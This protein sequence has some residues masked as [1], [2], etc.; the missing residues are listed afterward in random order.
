MRSITNHLAAGVDVR[1]GTTVT[2]IDRVPEGWSLRIETRDRAAVASEPFESVVM[3]GMP[4][5]TARV[6]GQHSAKILQEIGN[7]TAVPCWAHT[8]LLM[9][10]IPELPSVLR[11]SDDNLIELIVRDDAKPGRHLHDDLS[12]VVAYARAAWSASEYHAPSTTVGRKIADRLLEL[13]RSVTGRDVELSEFSPAAAHRWGLARPSSINTC[14][15]AV[16]EAL[17]LAACGD[18]FAGSG[19]EAAFLSGR[20]A[21]DAVLSFDHQS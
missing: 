14:E 1:A 2:S 19:L 10:R 3:A 5:Q 11:V 17:R 15:Y 20:A 9:G 12:M 8:M 18:G 21:A 13:L 7:S 16:D 4:Q 6:F